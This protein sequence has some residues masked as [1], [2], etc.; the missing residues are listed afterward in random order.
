MQDSR[1]AWDV[2]KIANMIVC[3]QFNSIE[4]YD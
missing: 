4:S 2:H 1:D 3:L